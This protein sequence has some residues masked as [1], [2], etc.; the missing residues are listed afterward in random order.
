MS[1][2]T[3]YFD[4][5]S[6]FSYLQTHRFRDLPHGQRIIF[7]PVLFAGLLN[8][9]RNKGPAE[10]PPKRVFTY[11]YVHWFAHRHGIPFRMP[12]AHPFNPLKALRL[13]IAAGATAESV[14]QIFHFI[15]AEGRAI[16]DDSAWSALAKRVGVDNARFQTAEVKDALRRNT[17]QAAGRGVF[18]VPTF[19]ID[20]NLFWGMD[21]TDMLID[22]L[23]RHAVF[24]SAEMQRVS[25]LPEGARRKQVTGNG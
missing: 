16:E 5:V 7:M 25:A 3:W 2:L 17:E 21:A 6:P 9:W 24:N 13:C 19:E 18:G 4:F 8:H 10:V 1:Q 12:P 14:Q 11:R 15:W 22:Y 23:S 20:G